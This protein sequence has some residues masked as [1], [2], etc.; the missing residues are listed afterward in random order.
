MLKRGIS[1]LVKANC[2]WQA[3]GWAGQAHRNHSWLSG[4]FGN[5]VEIVSHIMQ[6]FPS[7]TGL[8]EQ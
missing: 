4:D 1:T 8:V 6:A 2:W 5:A 7:Y 3:T